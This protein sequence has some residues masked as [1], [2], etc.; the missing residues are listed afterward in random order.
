MKPSV[1]VRLL[2]TQSD[3]RLAQLARAGHE[4]AFE[5]LV[6]RYRRSLLGYCRRLLLPEER[7]EDALQQGLLQAWLALRAGTEVR[8][9]KPWLYRIVHNAALNMRRSG[10]D[11]ARLSE[12]L[13]GASAPAEDLDRRIAVRETL[14]G[15]AALPEMQR[16]ALLHTAVEGAS[17]EQAAVVMGLSEGAVRG[18]VY[19]ARTALRAAAGALVPSPL[20]NWALSAGGGDAPLTSRLA[21]LGAGGS[22]GLA[23]VLLKTGA[24]AVTAGVL[25]GGIALHH[26]RHVRSHAPSPRS[27][28][29]IAEASSARGYAALELASLSE[30]S[31]SYQERLRSSAGAVSGSSLSRAYRSP[32]LRAPRGEV[33]EG[34]RRRAPRRS[35]LNTAPMQR[36]TGLAATPDGSVTPSSA[37]DRKDGGGSGHDGG[38]G[39]SEGHPGPN[40]GDGSA[41]G[42]QGSSTGTPGQ[43]SDGHEPGSAPSGPGS[44]GGGQP[45]SGNT[46]GPGPTNAGGSDHGSPDG[47]GGGDHE[48]HGDGSSAPRT[49]PAKA[50]LG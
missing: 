35:A 15:L 26:H 49:L 11:Y 14:A 29:A 13:C 33:G 1:S 32:A 40:P 21:E 38:G 10:Y 48:A 44:D 45:G 22:A 9:V 7:A 18:L 5:A 31:V 6:A 24:T 30:R 36:S 20:V 34:R 43:S 17:H 37:G 4:R 23:G 16:E 19:R 12:S 8:A 39:G 42:G 3:V 50:A 27:A 25:V 46:Q 28:P 41:P 2:L 47:S